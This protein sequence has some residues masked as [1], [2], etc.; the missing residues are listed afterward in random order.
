MSKIIKT[1][2]AI[3][4]SCTL[5]ACGGGSDDAD[6]STT[7]TNSQNGNNTGSTESKDNAP[8]ITI[9][10]SERSVNE[11]E[12]L[13]LSIKVE[14]DKAISAVTALS[15]SES[16]V[17]ES[18]SESE[19]AL[20]AGKVE[21]DTKITLTITATD[22]GSNKTEE[23]V[24]ITITDVPKK[25]LSDYV[26][27]E[28]AIDSEF[29]IA[30]P[31]IASAGELG[32]MVLQDFA[33][34]GV[35]R[36]KLGTF[37]NNDVTTFKEE[38]D[39]TL[40]DYFPDNKS[41]F[42]VQT[43]PMPTLVANVKGEAIFT[44]LDRFLIKRG[45]DGTWTKPIELLAHN[46]GEFK[47]THINKDGETS[48]VYATPYNYEQGKGSLMLLK[49]DS[50]LNTVNA[51][52]ELTHSVDDEVGMR[53][54]LFSA[55]GDFKILVDQNLLEVKGN[56]VSVK[57][58]SVK[59]R[60]FLGDKYILA[61]NESAVNSELNLVYELTDGEPKLVAKGGKE[62]LGSFSFATNGKIM[63]F[64]DRGFNMYSDKLVWLVDLETGVTI[65]DE[66]LNWNF[67]T[68][69]STMTE[70]GETILIHDAPS[71]SVYGKVINAQ[72][73]VLKSKVVGDYGFFGLDRPARYI[74]LININGEYMATATSGKGAFVSV[75][76][77]AD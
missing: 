61:F 20:R 75:L 29:S 39:I 16:L 13:T 8:T 23:K 30:S 71:S 6:S 12:Q 18:V 73:E 5:V 43:M 54:V 63:S 27:Q 59:A 58:L 38:A 67:N 37:S 50:E 9:N 70:T 17:V 66:I 32:V 22:S 60:R 46:E 26:W 11:L 69:V 3:L 57:A 34:R 44:W 24:E 15:S 4:L 28:Q 2:P 49:L 41:Y 19:I 52:S 40:G 48:I 74:E 77:Q 65:Y 36:L 7:Q 51:A 35:G 45:A 56:E 10:S 33:R 42:F 14:D 62:Q 64:I 25:S 21:A 72:G 68:A 53:D 55:N 47:A 31:M 1:L 76:K